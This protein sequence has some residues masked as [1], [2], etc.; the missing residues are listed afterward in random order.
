MAAISTRRLKE[1]RTKF[2][3]LDLNG[4]HKLDFNEIKDLLR[5]EKRDL[6][7]KAENGTVDST[8]K[9]L[10][11]DADFNGD[12]YVNFHEFLDL[13][14][15][16]TGAP[17]HLR[18]R[19]TDDGHRAIEA[20]ASETEVVGKDPDKDFVHEFPLFSRFLDSA[21]SGV[22][23]GNE[24]TQST[25]QP[26]RHSWCASA[27]TSG[28]RRSSLSRHGEHMLERWEARG[29]REMVLETC[30]RRQPESG[31]MTSR[32]NKPSERTPPQGASH[33]CGRRASV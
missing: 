12:S 1:L 16:K 27:D 26:R 22:H 21:T 32:S 15:F 10:F 8:V 18:K 20:D 28:L 5:R 23:N 9:S 17:V 25:S 13:M 24:P 7:Q 19:Q 14:H 30:D 6:V 3:L 11:E 29:L 4:D 33:R 31:C 2:D